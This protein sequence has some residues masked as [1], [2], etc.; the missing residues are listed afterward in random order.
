MLRQL[1]KHIV[2]IINIA[3][4]VILLLSYLAPYVP[5]Q[6][7]SVFSVIGLGYSYLL[8]INA[9]FIIF[10]ALNRK[11]WF[12]ISLLT[13]FIG[14]KHFNNYIK[15]STKNKPELL[16]DNQLPEIKI[17]SYNV[18]VFNLYNW[19]NNTAIRDSILKFVKNQN[20]DIICF[21]EYFN[22]KNKSFETTKPLL[23]QQRFKY[24]NIHNHYNVGDQQFGI[25]TFS[26]YPI[27]NKGV[28]NYNQNGN[29]IIYSDIKI[30]NQIIRVY[31][32]HLESIR[33]NHSDYNII[34]SLGHAVEKK[35]INQTRGVFTRLNRAF[36]ARARQAENLSNHIKNSPYP[37]IVCG[38]F[39]DTPISYTYKKIKETLTDSFTQQGLGRGI[40][41]QRSLFRFRID[42]ILYSKQINCNGFNIPDVS[43][44]DHYPITGYYQLIPEKQ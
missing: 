35:R 7:T 11:F 43:F 36:I 30:H 13:I 6:I 39:N 44:S 23:K 1:I 32:C 16:T 19:K 24:S 2:L 33:F 38:D 15:I 8:Y 28:L 10:W 41:Y 4:S 14:Y 42:Y 40:T 5:P 26:A 37:V 18:K 27:I 29:L 20:P 25:A 3:A 17:M 12:L 9:G 22:R 31:N 34:D 21:Q